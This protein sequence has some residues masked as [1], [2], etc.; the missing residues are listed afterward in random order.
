LVFVRRMRKIAH[1][2]RQRAASV[3]ERDKPEKKERP[4]VREY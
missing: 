1:R 2:G 4:P 3:R